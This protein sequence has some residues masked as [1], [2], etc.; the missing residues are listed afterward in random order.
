ML[1]C[2]HI[3]TIWQAGDRT[4]VTTT[5]YHGISWHRRRSEDGTMAWHIMAR[6]VT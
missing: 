4:M 6:Q 1:R 5:A 3:D 2:H